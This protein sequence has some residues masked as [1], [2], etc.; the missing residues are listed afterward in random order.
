MK[1]KK[2]GMKKEKQ[3]NEKQGTHV[4][5]SRGYHLISRA[6]G[7]K[8]WQRGSPEGRQYEK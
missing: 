5:F 4:D 7:S 3:K 8:K 1:P 2:R 6:I